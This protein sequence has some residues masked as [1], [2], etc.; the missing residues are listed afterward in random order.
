MD[1]TMLL[2]YLRVCLTTNKHVACIARCYYDG[3]VLGF[4]R[5]EQANSTREVMYAT[6]GYH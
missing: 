3:H 2:D 1:M 5:Q 6:I 4:V